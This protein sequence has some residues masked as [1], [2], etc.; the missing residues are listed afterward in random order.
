MAELARRPQWCISRQRAWGVPIPTL[1]DVDSD[2]VFTSP[3]FIRYIA[4]LIR[5]TPASNSPEDAWWRCS[6]EDFAS[7]EVRPEQCLKGCQYI[8]PLQYRIAHAR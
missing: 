8:N 2:E 7:D 3:K 5:N 6:I 1:I 4:Q